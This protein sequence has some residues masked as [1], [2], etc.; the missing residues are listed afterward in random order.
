MFIVSILAGLSLLIFALVGLRDKGEDNIQ[1]KIVKIGF[2]LLGAFLLYVG[3]IDTISLFT[4]PS[5]YLEQ[6]R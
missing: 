3:I 2:I 1:N 4:D 5:G 6:R